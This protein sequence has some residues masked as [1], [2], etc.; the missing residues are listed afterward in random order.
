MIKIDRE[1]AIAAFQRYTAKYDITRDMIRL[2]LEHTYR[3][4]SLCER[5][6]KSLSLPQEEVDLA[7]ILG[8]L[9]DIGRFEQQRLYGTFND[10]ESIDHAQ[11]GAGIL[12]E[13]LDESISIRDF[14]D[15]DTE[16]GVI[17]TAVYWHS[18][19]RLPAE[20]DERTRMFCDLLRDADKI[21]IIRVNVEFPL[22]EIY[23]TTSEVLRQE[24]VSD[25]VMQAFEEEH[26]VLRSLKKTSVDHVVGHISLVYELVYPMSVRLV[27]EQ[28]YLEGLLF[29]SSENAVT[30]R[31]FEHI[32]EKMNRYMEERIAFA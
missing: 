15:D 26:A 19:Y 7:W 11:Y 5:I 30:R 6:A 1:K 14:L 10:A 2:K 21:D 12:F 13:G 23:N 18:A 24:Q 20:L 17:R 3:V 32:R 29:F 31:Q 22:E 4:C 25:A 16:D 28:G 8:L 27:G 9:H